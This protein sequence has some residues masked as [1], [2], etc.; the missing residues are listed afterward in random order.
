MDLLNAAC[1]NAAGVLHGAQNLARWIVEAEYRRQA[2]SSQEAVSAKLDGQPFAWFEEHV[3]NNVTG[4]RSC[5][6][7]RLAR[8][9]VG[10]S[11]LQS[12]AIPPSLEPLG[13][14]LDEVRAHAT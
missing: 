6:A 9:E 13:C 8:E 12:P 1:R 10:G 5:S 14:L 11:K 2:T 3:A 7:A 4:D